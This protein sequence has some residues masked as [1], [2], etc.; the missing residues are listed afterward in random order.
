MPRNI[1]DKYQIMVANREALFTECVRQ[2]HEYLLRISEQ[3][4]LDRGVVGVNKN[5]PEYG[6]RE[7]EMAQYCC[8][9]RLCNTGRKRPKYCEKY[10][11]RQRVFKCWGKWRHR[12]PESDRDVTAD[13]AVTGVDRQRSAGPFFVSESGSMCDACEFIESRQ[14]DERSISKAEMRGKDPL[15]YKPFVTLRN[16]SA[17]MQATE[18]KIEQRARHLENNHQA[19]STVAAAAAAAPPQNMDVDDEEMDQEGEEEEE[20]ATA[21]AHKTKNAP[22]KMM[23]CHYPLVQ[24]SGHAQ[25]QASVPVSLPTTTNMPPRTPF[26]QRAN[27]TIITNK[28]NPMVGRLVTGEIVH[29]T[30]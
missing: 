2:T 29:F 25:A 9:I 17:R 7:K 20:E 3:R 21:A 13:S 8:S 24:P 4:A 30:F 10:C 27:S 26:P 23:R 15:V 1:H 16:L 11:C 28:N 12:D 18:R 5:H 19:S 14:Q 22:L 6:Q